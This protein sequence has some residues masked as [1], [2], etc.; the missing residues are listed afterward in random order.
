QVGLGRVGSGRVGSGRVGSGRVGSGRV[1]PLG[2]RARRLSSSLSASCT[3]PLVH[4]YIQPLSIPCPMLLHSPSSLPHV[5]S[6]FPLPTCKCS[7]FLDLLA[8]GSYLV[9]AVPNPIT[10]DHVAAAAGLH[11]RAMSAL[12]LLQLHGLPSAGISSADVDGLPV[13]SV[14]H[15]NGALMQ[16]LMGSLSTTKRDRLP[17]MGPAVQQ[18]APAIEAFPLTGIALSVAGSFF[19]TPSHPS[20]PHPIS[21]LFTRSYPTPLHPIPSHP[22][23]PWSPCTEQALEALQ[24]S[25]IPLPPGVVRNDLDPL[26]RFLEQIP[27][28]LGQVRLPPPLTCTT[29]ATHV[30]QVQ[31]P[32]PLTLVTITSHTWDMYARQMALRRWQC[33][34]TVLP[35][36]LSTCS[37]VHLFICPLVH[38]S[39]CPS[40]HV[41]FC[42]LV[43]LSTCPSVHVSTRHQ[44]RDGVSE[45]TPP[46]A[47]T[48]KLIASSYAVPRNLLIKFSVDTLDETDQLEPILMGRMEEIG[49]SVSTLL[50]EGTHATPLAPDVSWPVQDSFSPV[51][52]IAQGVKS[53]ALVDIR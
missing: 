2:P 26:G 53:S 52:A 6:P 14:G 31:L 46:P 30:G 11:A 9:V 39:T 8:K 12:D 40:A 3:H 5:R 27:P 38:M 41:S 47:E 34:N 23:L 20:S 49:G 1:G 44:V 13:Y 24:R 36:C 50:L 17:E 19:D 4:F 37:S 33:Y 43:H 42:P 16:L 51:D 22:T 45:F 18:L 29:N 15:S 10:F 25:S 28:V 48:R 32:P 21:P 7:Y 35:V